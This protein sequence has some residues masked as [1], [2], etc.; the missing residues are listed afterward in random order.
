MLCLT[1]S[2]EQVKDGDAESRTLSF[3][4]KQAPAIV[5]ALT[6]ACAFSATDQN[7][8]PAPAGDDDDGDD[9][10]DAA[11]PRAAVFLENRSLFQ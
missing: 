2:S 8:K 3:E 7:L 6:S 9:D 4:T 1:V 5:L 10:A 11:E